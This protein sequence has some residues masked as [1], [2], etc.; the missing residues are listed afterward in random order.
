LF[1]AWLSSLKT[2]PSLF[3]GLPSEGLTCSATFSSA[4]ATG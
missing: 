2:S 4:F 1:K 3:T